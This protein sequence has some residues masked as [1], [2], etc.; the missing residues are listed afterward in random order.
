M[1]LNT[2]R[3]ELEE[4][5]RAGYGECRVSVYPAVSEDEVLGKYVLDFT[6]EEYAACELDVPPSPADG[7][8][9]LVFDLV[10]EPADL[11]QV[12]VRRN[13]AAEKETA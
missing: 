13:V 3:A 9:M 6:G 11:T 4:L 1:N 7:L 12:S 2:L 8:V 10:D 5:E